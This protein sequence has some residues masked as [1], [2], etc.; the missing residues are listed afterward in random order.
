[1]K[2]LENEEN[3]VETDTEA[4]KLSGQDI[5]SDYV[6]TK[7]ADG[8]KF[9]FTAEAKKTVRGNKPVPGQKKDDVQIGDK[10]SAWLAKK[11]ACKNCCCLSH[12]V[13]LEHEAKSRDL[14]VPG[15][16]MF[17]PGLLDRSWA[18]DNEYLEDVREMAASD[19]PF[20][21][22]LCAVNTDLSEGIDAEKNQVEEMLLSPGFDTFMV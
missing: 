19:D 20:M 15:Q 8:L 7:I 18:D 6:M 2:V 16:Q 22:I 17:Y 13:V 4:Q 1:M 9:K 12:C 14:Q 11:K 21:S 5:P 10:L 3:A